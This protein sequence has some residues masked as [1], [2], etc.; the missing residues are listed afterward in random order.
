MPFDNSIYRDL[1]QNKKQT[2][3][4]QRPKTFCFEG[5]LDHQ[6]GGRRRRTGLRGVSIEGNRPWHMRKQSRKRA[7]AGKFHNFSLPPN[8]FQRT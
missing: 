2:E 8:T 7:G 6:F 5:Q 3:E 4:H 1:F